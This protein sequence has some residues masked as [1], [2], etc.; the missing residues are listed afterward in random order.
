M[1]C[2]ESRTRHRVD[3]DNT[4]FKN[5]GHSSLELSK[6]DNCDQTALDLSFV[7]R[8]V[9]T[10]CNRVETYVFFDTE[11]TGLQDAGHQ[12]K[13]T[14]FCL[15]AIQREEL[16]PS[17]GQPRVANKL[18]VCLNPQQV[19]TPSASMI[20]GMFNDHLASQTP[21]TSEMA[22]M[23]TSFLE[24][25]P[26]P[27][28]LIAHNGNHF[29]YPLLRSEL[30]QANESLPGR[31]L[32]ADSLECFREMTS[33]KIAAEMARDAANMRQDSEQT[34]SKRTAISDVL[35]VGAKKPR[36][37]PSMQD[38]LYSDVNKEA[39]TRRL[40]FESV[41]EVE[42]RNSRDGDNT[43]LPKHAD[44]ET[45]VAERHSA[46]EPISNR[47]PIKQ[48]TSVVKKLTFTDD[49]NHSVDCSNLMEDQDHIDTNKTMG[50]SC[51]YVSKR[52]ESRDLVTSTH[53]DCTFP[54]NLP[55]PDSSPGTTSPIVGQTAAV[56]GTP[57][58]DGGV[59]QRSTEC[60]K[61]VVHRDQSSFDK[62]SEK[63]MP[64]DSKDNL[65][66]KV[67][68][69]ADIDF[70]VECVENSS[71]FREHVSYKA[72]VQSTSDVVNDR[73]QSSSEQRDGIVRR[74][75]TA[76]IKEPKCDTTTPSSDNSTSNP[77]MSTIP[78]LPVTKYSPFINISPTTSAQMRNENQQKSEEVVHNRRTSPTTSK[79]S[80]TT[81][82]SSPAKTFPT[83][84]SF[85]LQEIY[86]R[87]YGQLPP[88]SHNAEDDCV[89]LLKVVM[90]HSPQFLDWVDKHAVLFNTIS[91]MY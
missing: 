72:E 34:P 41:E 17:C 20:T 14:E 10:C 5:S 44:A 6:T 19:I 27:V 23:V 84:L 90:K 49:V 67:D 30:K 46:K 18:T 70:A 3:T 75:E 9:D 91:P 66:H 54:V 1:A 29:D 76:L 59:T 53:H 15:L 33:G 82:E 47:I 85:K 56:V 40:D 87:C 24:R 78:P 25:L 51:V 22:K 88:A 64:S 52:C 68:F 32:C 26:S 83:R 80:T 35:P 42:S 16:Q 79:A 31:L 12:P 7:H 63:P 50:S 45:G 86:R 57:S 60:Q 81:T 38:I 73:P 65:R 36:K 61:A 58:Q 21:F 2:D 37:N 11:T 55:T 48:G 71:T 62:S 4:D 8:E 89:T 74:P 13:I 77:D 43:T 69:E 28:C 39:A